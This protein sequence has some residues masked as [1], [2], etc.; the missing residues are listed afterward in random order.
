MRFLLEQR[1]P[2][3]SYGRT[4]FTE[5]HSWVDYDNEEFA[6]QAAI[7]LADKGNKNICV[8]LPP[9]SQAFRQHLRY[10]VMRAVRETDVDHHI[11]TT[12]TLNSSMDEINAWTRTLAT[13]AQ[14]ADGFIC[15]G[16]ASYLAI[17]NAFGSHGLRVG[18]DHDAV[19]KSISGILAQIDPDTDTIH[20]GVEEAGR[21]MASQLVAILSDDLPSP[22]QYLQ[23][24]ETHFHD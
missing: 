11:P 12:V 23:A 10:G 21:R 8:I 15:L 9:N 22:P 7:R 3:V 1:F 20:E 17:R 6:D 14:R 4:E 16:E 18:R 13:S 24:P 19:V 2:F 5:P